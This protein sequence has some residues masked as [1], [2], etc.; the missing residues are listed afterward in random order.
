MNN[1]VILIP[2]YNDWDSL[3][4]LIPKIHNVIKDLNKNISII[5]INDS[6]TI[7]KRLIF[8]DKLCFNKIEILNLLENVKAQKAV[9]TTLYYLKKKKLQWWNYFYGCRWPR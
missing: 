2:C 3:N 6:S 8:K 5:I 7:K 4:V 9:A 1:F